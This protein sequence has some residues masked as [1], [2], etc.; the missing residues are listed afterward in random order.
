MQAEFLCTL[1]PVRPAMPD[2]PTPEERD[3]VGAHFAYYQSLRDR[4]VLV[5]AG[6]T[7]EPPYTGVFVFR[8]ESEDH[9]RA[10][11]DTDPAVAR[12]VMTATLQPFR[13]ALFGAD[14]TK[15]R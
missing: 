15:D 3:A 6:R 12:S 1:R 14:P 8:A 4:G 5:L 2:D 7:T 11:V 9:A 10:I 13:T